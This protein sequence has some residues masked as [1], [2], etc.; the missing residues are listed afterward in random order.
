MT[1]IVLYLFNNICD[2]RTQLPM[3]DVAGWQITQS[4]LQFLGSLKALLPA[5]PTK[6]NSSNPML[7]KPR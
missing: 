1:S 7:R 5:D 4:G 2:V 6:N 3:R